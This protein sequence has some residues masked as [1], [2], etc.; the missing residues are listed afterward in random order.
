MQQQ[1]NNN[2]AKSNETA[3]TNEKKIKYKRNTTGNATQAT[4]TAQHI[5][6]AHNKHDFHN[7]QL[8]H[9]QHKRQNSYDQYMSNATQTQ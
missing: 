2:K 3:T 5:A 7:T 6:R 9:Q 4:L 1:H 8:Q